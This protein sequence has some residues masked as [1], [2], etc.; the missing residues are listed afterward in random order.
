MKFSAPI[1]ATSMA[2]MF[3]AAGCASSPPKPVVPRVEQKELPKPIEQPIAADKQ[4]EATDRGAV[5]QA[6]QP[7][8]SEMPP[9]PAEPQSVVGPMEYQKSAIKL[10]LNADSRLNLYDRKPHTLMICLYQLK[11]PNAFNQLVEEADG[12]GRLMECSRF[13]PTV[14]QVKRMVVQPGSKLKEDLDRAEGAKYIAVV[15]G[16]YQLQKRRPLRLHRI[17]AGIMNLEVNLGALNIQDE[18]EK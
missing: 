2:L 1:I 12:F 17:P 6:Q 3:L 8:I 15:A 14:A 13:D 4:S 7:Q 10:V 9:K 11:D 18:G 16:Y 5:S